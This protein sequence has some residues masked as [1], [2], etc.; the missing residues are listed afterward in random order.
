MAQ[1]YGTAPVNA[2]KT[3]YNSTETHENCH[4]QNTTAKKKKAKP[5]TNFF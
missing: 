2:E 1:F 5:K 3:V 4:G